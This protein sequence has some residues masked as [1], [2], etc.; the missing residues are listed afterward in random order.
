MLLPSLSYPHTLRSPHPTHYFAGPW[1][2]AASEVLQVLVAS[3]PELQDEVVAN[4]RPRWRGSEHKG[5]IGSKSSGSLALD[6]VCY[7]L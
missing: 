7:L 3:D 4:V 1:T 5:G 6:L 2:E